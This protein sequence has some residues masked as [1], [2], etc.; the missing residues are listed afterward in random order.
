M[1]ATALALAVVLTFARVFRQRILSVSHR[2]EG[3]ARM[4]GCARGIG[5]EGHRPG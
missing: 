5:T 3:D 4:A 1:L 2:L